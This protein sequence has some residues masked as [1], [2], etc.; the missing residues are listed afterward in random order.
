MS[1]LCITLKNPY[2]RTY[3]GTSCRNAKF[4]SVL[5]RDEQKNFERNNIVQSFMKNIKPATPPTLESERTTS[6]GVER[7]SDEDQDDSAMLPPEVRKDML[8]LKVLEAIKADMAGEAL[9]LVQAASESSVTP[10]LE[11]LS[12]VGFIRTIVSQDFKDENVC[13][14]VGQGVCEKF[15][16]AQGRSVGAQVLPPTQVARGGPLLQEAQVSLPAH[17]PHREVCQMPISNQIAC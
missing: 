12:E 6:D 4:E 13:I 11:V 16:R 14:L 1:L 7:K 2:L 5:T 3:L 8:D 9:A 17:K 10:S 15:R